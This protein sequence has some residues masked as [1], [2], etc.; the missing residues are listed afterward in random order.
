MN[1][2]GH[3]MC[4]AFAIVMAFL[5]SSARAHDHGIPFS[6]QFSGTITEPSVTSL[7]PPTVFLIA[8]GT[9]E[10]S[11]LGQSQIVFPHSIIETTGAVTGDMMIIT[12]DGDI[13]LAHITGTALPTAT[14]GE[15][16]LSQTGTFIGGTG[17]FVDAMGS[18]VVTGSADTVGLTVTATLDG[19]LYTCR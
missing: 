9:S 1:Q 10:V 6:A 11:P 3:L 5:S 18:F 13:L 19:Y 15:F 14:P 7:A 4:A 17:R 16:A 2:K 8:Y 12:P